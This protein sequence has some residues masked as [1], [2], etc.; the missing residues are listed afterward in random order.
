VKFTTGDH[1]L[2]HCGAVLYNT[3]AAAIGQDD[4]DEQ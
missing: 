3:G 4:A 1:S 2:R